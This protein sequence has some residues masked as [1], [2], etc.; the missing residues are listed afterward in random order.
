MSAHVRNIK[1]KNC[2]CG[3]VHN[4][5][6]F[7]AAHAA[8]R[9]TQE[10]SDRTAVQLTL[11]NSDL[12][13]CL[14]DST[15]TLSTSRTGGQGGSLSAEKERQRCKSLAD[16]KARAP[17]AC[18]DMNDRKGKQ[19][20]WCCW[21]CGCNCTHSTKGCCELSEEDKENHK[22]ATCKT[23]LGGNTKFIGCH[24]KCQIDCDFDSL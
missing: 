6:Q 2:S 15:L 16:A 13:L 19:F 8:Q 20:K 3:E 24:G 12:H 21:H 4:A 22:Q 14:S 11:Q 9:Q 17:D 10:R 1:A 7:G 5:E 23:A 18:K